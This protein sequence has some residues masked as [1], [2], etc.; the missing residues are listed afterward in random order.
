MK[1][2]ILAVFDRVYLRLRPSHRRYGG[3][4]FTVTGYKCTELFCTNNISW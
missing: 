4:Q 1:K 2:S 3:G